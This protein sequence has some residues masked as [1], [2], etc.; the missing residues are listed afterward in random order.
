MF[1]A[2]STENHDS[3]SNYEFEIL[4]ITFIL[5]LPK[6]NVTS[7]FVYVVIIHLPLGYPMHRF[8]IIRI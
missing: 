3:L 6:A 5:L 8:G 7:F 1:D 2:C 4:L